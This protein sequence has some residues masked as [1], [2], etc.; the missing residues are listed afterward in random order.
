MRSLAQQ[1][2]QDI[3]INFGQGDALIMEDMRLRQLGADDFRFV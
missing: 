3:V 1:I 2:G